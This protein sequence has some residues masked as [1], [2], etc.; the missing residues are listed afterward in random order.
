[1]PE[2]DTV[3]RAATRLN[4]A[5]AGRELTRFELRVPKYAALDLAGLTVDEVVPRGKHLLTR[6]GPHT[7]HTHLGMDGSWQLV[8]AGGKWPR[9][10]YQARAV[11]GTTVGS[12]IGFE[13]AVVEMLASE[14]EADA[15]GHLGPD[16]LGDDWDAQLAVA[17]LRRD[18][19]AELAGALLEQRNLAGLGNVY[20]TELLFLRGLHPHTPVSGA[21]DLDRLVELGHKLIVANRDRVERTTT[22]DLRPGRRTYVYGRYGKPCLRCGTRIQRGVQGRERVAAW[23]PSCQPAP[24]A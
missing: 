17:N 20:V 21:G 12:A 23:C 10:A 4:R 19:D 9:P 8:A 2:G 1:M 3:Y 13:L 6:I 15:V 24:P 11:L 16:L 14:D 22:G 7:L 18:P 5:L